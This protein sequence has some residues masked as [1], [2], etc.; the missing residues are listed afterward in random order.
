MTDNELKLEVLKVSLDLARENTFSKRGAL[1]S[2]WESRT[3][4]APYPDLP[5]I[6]LDEVV[7]NYVQFMSVIWGEA[8]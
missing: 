2:K 6:S 1:V 3:E 5:Q 8:R 7:L 4:E